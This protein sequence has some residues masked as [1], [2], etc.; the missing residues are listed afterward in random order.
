MNT[1]QAIH[2]FALVI[3]A[4]LLGLCFFSCEP[5][6]EREQLLGDNWHFRG[7]IPATQSITEVVT[8]LPNTVA[9]P[10]RGWVFGYCDFQVNSNMRGRKELW[11]ILGRLEFP[12]EVSLNGVFLYRR[13]SLPPDAPFVQPLSPSVFLVPSTIWNFQGSNH[14][15]LRIWKEGAHI[16]FPEGIWVAGPKEAEFQRELVHFSN[17]TLFLVFF[18]INLLGG[19]YFLFLW[20]SGTRQRDRLYFAIS[21]LLIGFYFLSLGSPVPLFPGFIH[22]SL[23]KACLGPSIGFLILFIMAHFKVQLFFGGKTLIMAG[24]SLFSV[25]IVASTSLWQTL[26]HFSTS[27]ISLEVAMLFT[28]ILM[29]KALRLRRPQALIVAIGIA[30]GVACGSHDVWFHLSGRM[31]FAWLQGV[32]FFAMEVSMFFSLAVQSNHVH[33][34]LAESTHELRVQKDFLSLTNESFAR[35]VPRELLGFLGKDSIMDVRLGDQVQQNMTVLFSDIRNFTQISESMTP[36]ESFN[37]LNS[38]LARMGP[39]IRDHGGIVDKYIGDA[40]MALFSISP[41]QAVQAALAM[42][43]LLLVHNEGRLRAG[44]QVLEMGIG[45]HF[46]PV[47]LGT[48]GEAKRMDGTVISDAVNT[49]SRIEGLTKQFKISIIASQDLLAADLA[50]ADSVPHRYLGLMAVKGKQKDIALYEILDMKEPLSE[51]KITHKELFESAVRALEAKQIVEAANL[52]ACYATK[53][54]LDPC[55][56]FFR[57]RLTAN[58]LRLR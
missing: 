20:A 51:Q 35:F 27:L 15:E 26:D 10:Y 3:V 54:P 55:L 9:L 52:F 7:G 40:I 29:I 14:L 44:Y 25:Y 37:M 48:I 24:V 21:T 2:R 39:C 28:I 38:Y 23:L 57:D 46:G 45:L 17:V 13:G 6:G 34:K 56:D 22:F 19:V 31:P 43:H 50:I 11:L 41:V 30:V 42:R 16:S 32:G 58:E 4:I 1:C 49:A 33:N 18:G 36:R 12:L 8:R 47:I 53:V 5:H